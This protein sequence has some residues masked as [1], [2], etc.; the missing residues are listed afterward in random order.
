MAR[1]LTTSRAALLVPNHTAETTQ[2]KIA[3][4]SLKFLEEKYGAEREQN[5]HLDNL[6][7]RME[8]SLKFFE[9]ELE[10]SAND[11]RTS[12]NDFQGIYLEMLERQR[13]LLSQMNQKDEFDEDLIRKYLSLI[14][15]EEFKIRE[16]QL[17]EEAAT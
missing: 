7:Q 17:P 1:S 5:E 15:V 6:F 13:N 14:D 2:K 11:R 3:A 16:K 10:E 4:A 9:Q 12:L 8:I